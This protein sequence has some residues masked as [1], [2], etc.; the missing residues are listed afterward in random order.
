MF[1]SCVKDS[2]IEV[3]PEPI[4]FGTWIGDSVYYYKTLNDSMFLNNTLVYSVFSPP[5]TF[6]FYKK[7]Q[8][9]HVFY[10]VGKLG[11]FFDVD[12]GYFSINNDSVFLNFNKS[13][14]IDSLGFEKL[15]LLKPSFNGDSLVKYV[16]KKNFSLLSYSQDIFPRWENMCS[17]CHYKNSKYVA[18][19]PLSVGYNNLINDSSVNGDYSNFADYVD[20]L[21]PEN[22][23]LYLKIEGTAPGSIMPQPPYSPLPDYQR[24]LILKWIKQGALFN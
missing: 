13:F 20:T 3:A 16:Y 18:L 8:Y 14:F 10:S 24:K 2:F 5:D 9:K 15:V 6:I 23:L 4:I 21:N 12:S 11:G 17:N 22:S 7:N 19:S 1:S